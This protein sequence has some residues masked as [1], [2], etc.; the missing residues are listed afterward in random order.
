V[1]PCAALVA[2]LLLLLLLLLV[3]VLLLL[4]LLLLLLLLLQE[5]VSHCAPDDPT[6]LQPSKLT[7]SQLRDHLRALNLDTCGTKPQLVARLSAAKTWMAG[8]GTAAAAGGGDGASM[9]AAAAAAV[10][11]SDT[12]VLVIGSDSGDEVDKAEEALAAALSGES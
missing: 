10:A 12:E 2:L 5:F 9:S 6:D 7:C 4:V 1:A 8:A 11:D 3:L